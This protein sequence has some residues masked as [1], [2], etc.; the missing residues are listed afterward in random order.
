MHT[1][2]H[3]HSRARSRPYTLRVITKEE[4]AALPYFSFSSPL[5][6]STP[7]PGPA[8]LSPHPQPSAPLDGSWRPAF[9]SSASEPQ[10]RAQAP[11]PCSPAGGRQKLRRRRRQ[12]G[13]GVLANC[14]E[15]CV[16]APGAG[17]R[18]GWGGGGLRE[19]ERRRQP[20]HPSSATRQRPAPQPGLENK[21]SALFSL[22][23]G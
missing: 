1:L 7:A 3:R 21:L 22:G 10:L 15:M 11:A 23:C 20:P 4:R 2:A 17:S 12:R 16:C 14:Q 6:S 13:Q 18:Q 19:G 9:R 8:C 5:F